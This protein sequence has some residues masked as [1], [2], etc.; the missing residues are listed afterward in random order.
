MMGM[1]G[2][3]VVTI[4]A[5]IDALVDVVGFKPDTPLKV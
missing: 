4:Y 1:Q 3:D 2:G 5:N